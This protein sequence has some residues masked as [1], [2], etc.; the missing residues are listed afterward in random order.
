MAV[1]EKNILSMCSAVVAS[2][3]QKISQQASYGERDNKKD[4]YLPPEDR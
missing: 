3:N 1:S 2:W 4:S